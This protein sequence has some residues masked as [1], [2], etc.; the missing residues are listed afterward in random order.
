MQYHPLGPRHLEYDYHVAYE[1]L[2]EATILAAQALHFQWP[3]RR[4][5]ITA[6]KPTR[7]EVMDEL[8]RPT[9]AEI[10]AAKFPYVERARRKVNEADQ[11]LQEALDRGETWEN[12]VVPEAV[13]APTYEAIEGNM[14][15]PAPPTPRWSDS[16]KVP[17]ARADDTAPRPA[18]R[19][20][21]P[22]D[23]QVV[24][25]TRD[26]AQFAATK[27]ILDHKPKPIVGKRRRVVLSSEVDSDKTNER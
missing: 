18:T 3:K 21:V 13:L 19:A 5:R 10:L 14:P 8:S 2:R 23:T 27:A 16:R 15:P 4:P 26:K 17:K 1:E 7:E 20:S 9:L 11:R 6:S 25:R 22:R 12:T 24:T